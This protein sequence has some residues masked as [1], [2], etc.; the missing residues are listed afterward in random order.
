VPFQGQL[1]TKRPLARMADLGV[2]PDNL[3]GMT[4]G[5]RLPSGKPSLLV[6]SDDNFSSFDPPQLNQ[7]LLFELNETEGSPA[8]PLPGGGSP[9]PAVVR[10]P[11]PVQVPAVLPRTGLP[12]QVGLGLAL[13]GL[14]VGS[15]GLLLR[16]R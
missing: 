5:P 3:E 1:V 11:G 12:P 7:F 15:A 16:R 6:I 10:T 4:Y 2:E 8:A 13:I 9:T 14:A